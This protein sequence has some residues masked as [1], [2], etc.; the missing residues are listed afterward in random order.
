MSPRIYTV[1]P[2]ALIYFYVWA[3]L[4]RPGAQPEFGRWS[5]SN[6]IAYFGAGSVVAI[7]YYQLAPQWIIAGWALVVVG[8]VVAALLLD[9]EVFL[10]QTALLTAAIAVRGLAHNIF[11]ASYFT[12]G[13]WRGKFSAIALTSALLFATLPIAFRIC[14]RFKDRPRGSLLARALAARRPDQIL[15]FVPLL[16]I[17]VTIAVKMESSMVTLAWGI[18]G[19]LVIVIGLLSNQRSYRLTGL[20]LLLLCIGKIVLRDAWYLDERSRYITFIVL[21][22]ALILVSALYSKYRDQVS[23]LL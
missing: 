10:E 14:S 20:A 6:V 23:R 7:L 11:G 12:S 9:Q 4:S 16:L 21:G 5:A 8:L 2:L 22:V 19:L 15:F 3:R 17:V 18:V 13:G 1:A